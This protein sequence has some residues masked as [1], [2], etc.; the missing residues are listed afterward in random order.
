MFWD[1][2]NRPIEQEPSISSWSLKSDVI[3]AQPLPIVPEVE[4]IF[5][6]RERGKGGTDQNLSFSIHRKKFPTQGRGNSIGIPKNLYVCHFRCFPCLIRSPLEF[7]NPTPTLL[8]LKLLVSLKDL[9]L[10]WTCMASW[11]ACAC[12]SKKHQSKV[13]LK[14]I[15]PANWFQGGKNSCVEIPGQKNSEK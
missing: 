10:E 11:L 4:K 15:Y 5:Y 2:R 13:I 8:N 3:L 7:L 1:W 14:N 6:E 12:L 9:A